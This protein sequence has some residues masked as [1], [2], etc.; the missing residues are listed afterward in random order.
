MKNLAKLLDVPVGYFPKLDANDKGPAEEDFL[1]LIAQHIFDTKPKGVVECGSGLSTVVIARCLEII[2]EPT[3]LTHPHCYSMDHL[4][5]YG[6]RTTRW[7]DERKLSQ[8]ATVHTFSVGGEPPFYQYTMDVPP[9]DLL[10]IDGPPGTLH[11]MA[12]YGA[13]T[14]FKDLSPDSTIFL[15]DQK[16]PGEIMVRDAWK[17]DYE[18]LGFRFEDLDTVRGT[19]KITRAA[20]VKPRVLVSVPSLMW[21]HRDMFRPLWEIGNDS[22]FDITFNF[23]VRKPVEV[24]YCEMAQLVHEKNYDWW[25]SIDD[26][27]PPT[28]N[29]LDLIQLDKDIIGCPTPIWRPDLKGKMFSWNVM[30]YDEKDGIHYEWG[31]PNGLQ[32]VDALGMG[33]T[34]ISGRVFQNETMRFQPFMREYKSTGMTLRGT[35]VAF[36]KRA[37]E[38]GFEVWAHFD[39]LCKHFKEIEL[40]SLLKD[41]NGREQEIRDSYEGKNETI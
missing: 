24:A 4:A 22:R 10:V 26:D 34:L 23:P 3:A 8:Y 28:R 25:L 21:I 27:N 38:N 9:I 40:T 13:K 16:R 18:R 32:E 20:K 7:L 6:D 36:C 33:C 14:L 35:D 41:V 31:D 11:P 5:V 29:P 1:L 17:F 12:R 2:N 30:S 15:D 19:C 37:K 39:Y